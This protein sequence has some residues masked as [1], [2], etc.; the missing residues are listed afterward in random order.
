MATIKFDELRRTL[1]QHQTDLDK[2]IDACKSKLRDATDAGDEAEIA[3]LTKEL[4]TR[5]R[6]KTALEGSIPIAN[7]MCCDQFFNCPDP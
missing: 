1:K 4:E 7:L 5:E 3:R 6:V 2:Q